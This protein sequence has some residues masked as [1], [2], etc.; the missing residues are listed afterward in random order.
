MARHTVEITYRQEENEDGREQ[1]C[2]Y[3]TCEDSGA[4]CGPIWGHSDASVKRA[5]A[6]LSE[7]CEGFHV[8]G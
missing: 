2:V 8:E 3:A 4:T 5:L 1:D 7:E 6:T